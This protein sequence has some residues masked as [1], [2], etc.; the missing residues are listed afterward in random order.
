MSAN[1]A[2]RRAFA[3]MLGVDPGDIKEVIPV[4]YSIKVERKERPNGPT[5][6]YY[7]TIEVK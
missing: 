3:T 4:A 7:R 6:T 2:Q 5:S 1:E